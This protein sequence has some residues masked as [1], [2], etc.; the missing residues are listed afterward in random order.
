MKTETMEKT[1]VTYY[2]DRV[3]SLQRVKRPGEWQGKHQKTRFGIQYGTGGE[4]TDGNY[5]LDGSFEWFQPPMDSRTGLIANPLDN[6]KRVKTREFPDEEITEQ[7]WFERQLGLNKGFLDPNRQLQLPNGQMVPYSYYLKEGVIKVDKTGI[8]LDLKIP[9]DLLKYKVLLSCRK[10]IASSLEEAKSR[11][12]FKYAIVDSKKQ[13]QAEMNELKIKMDAI[14]SFNKIENS[15]NDMLDFLA[16][17]ENNV[18][19]SDNIEFVKSKCFQISQSNPKEFIRIVNDGNKSYTITLLKA[20]KK[21]IIRRERDLTY[22]LPNGQNIGP[23][24]QAISWLQNPENFDQ[25]EIIKSK[26]K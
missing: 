6:V 21:G 23:Q 3:V 9:Q 20:H 13:Q 8:I 18:T 11:P 17:Y 4:V 10:Q 14:K 24:S 15:L 22:V 2:E 1:L 25:L 5:Q 19:E 7:E 26:I 12:T 16:I